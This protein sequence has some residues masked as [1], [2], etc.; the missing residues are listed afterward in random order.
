LAE[1]SDDG[2]KGADPVDQRAGFAAMLK[3]IASNGVRTVLVETASRFARDLIIQETGWRFLRDAGINLIAA[4]SPDSFLDETPTAVLI[5]QVLGAV[6]QFEKA[7]LVAKLTGLVTS[8]FVNGSRN[9]ACEH[10]RTALGFEHA[11]VAVVLSIRII[12]S[13]SIEGRPTSL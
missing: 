13:G 9:L 11:G 6:S 1:Y 4:D 7:A 2:A 5:R 3:H 12:S 8:R 10:I